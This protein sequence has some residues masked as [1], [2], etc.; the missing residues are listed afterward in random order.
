MVL[1]A[2]VKTKVPDMLSMGFIGSLDAKRLGLEVTLSSGHLPVWLRKG[3][4]RASIGFRPL[5]RFPQIF[6]LPFINQSTV[7]IDRNRP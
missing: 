3:K 7:R 2:N 4:T 5:D 6:A 1:R